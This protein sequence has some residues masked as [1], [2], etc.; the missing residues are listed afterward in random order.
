MSISDTQRMK[1][2]FEREAQGAKNGLYGLAIVSN[3]EAITA[4]ME[5]M[6]DRLQQLNQAGMQE[7][8]R[9][10]LLNDDVWDVKGELF[11]GPGTESGHH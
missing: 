5:R 1:K 4:R 3:H 9:A 2:S 11:D 6:Y 10:I 7:E 8:V